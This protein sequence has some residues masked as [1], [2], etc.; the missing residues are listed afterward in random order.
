MENGK[1]KIKK[2]LITDDRE[3]DSVSGGAEQETEFITVSGSHCPNCKDT[4]MQLTGAG[5]T[6][7]DIK[8]LYTVY[9]CPTCHGSYR[10]L[11]MIGKW[12]NN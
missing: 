2:N 5:G 9:T 1:N 6:S 3:L 7:T 12:T 8:N 11:F 4:K 10:Y